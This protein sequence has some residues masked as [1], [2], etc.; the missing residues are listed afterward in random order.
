MSARHL[1][2]HGL[3][4]GLLLCGLAS[5]CVLGDFKKGPPFAIGGSDNSG[6]NVTSTATR[7][8]PSQHREPAP[9]ALATTRR[10]IR[11]A[12]PTTS[13]P[14][15]CA[16][17]AR[18]LK[19]AAP[20]AHRVLPRPHSALPTPTPPV[21]S[22]APATSTAAAANAYRAPVS[23]PR[24]AARRRP[25]HCELPAATVVPVAT[26]RAVPKPRYWPALSIVATTP[27]RPR[28][29]ATSRSIPTK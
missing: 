22:S 20:T 26:P 11:G 19:R 1:L 25:R 6:G 29:S 10:P 7:S 24:G 3:P 16:N 28:P 17:C 12:C 5:S 13:A 15:V 8:A 21:A 9:A 23:A 27:A 4:I 14:A 2:G 18:P